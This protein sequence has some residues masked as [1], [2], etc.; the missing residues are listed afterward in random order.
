MAQPPR[1]IG[2]YALRLYACHSTQVNMLYLNHSQIGR[3]SIYLR[4][5]D[6]R[7]SWSSWLVTYRDGLPDTHP[8]KPGPS[9]YRATSSNLHSDL[10]QSILHHSGRPYWCIQVFIFSNN[11]TWLEVWNSLDTLSRSLQAYSTASSWH[12]LLLTP[13]TIAVMG[14]VHCW[15]FTEVPKYRR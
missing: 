14:W 11:N 6:R 15:V 10:Y 7:L 5:R 2:P 12:L 3:N 1:K 8:C 9:R 13:C 4:R